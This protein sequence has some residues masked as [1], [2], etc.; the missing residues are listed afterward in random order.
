MDT[1][2]NNSE[3]DQDKSWIPTWN[4]SQ[5][6]YSQLIQDNFKIEVKLDQQKMTTMMIF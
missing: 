6:S 1:I 3:D 2:I 4:D 5:Y